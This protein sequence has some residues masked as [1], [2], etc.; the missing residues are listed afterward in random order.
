MAQVD[1]EAVVEE[2]MGDQVDQEGLVGPV[3]PED[4]ADLGVLGDGRG[5]LILLIPTS[6]KCPENFP[7]IMHPTP[8]SGCMAWHVGASAPECLNMT[9]FWS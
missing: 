7:E 5:G 1:L 3:D 4:P 2:M 8:P 9:M 6:C